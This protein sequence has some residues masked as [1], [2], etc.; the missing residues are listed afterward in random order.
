MDLR[1]QLQLQAERLL[2]QASS[3]DPIAAAP[4][5][6]AAALASLA[7]RTTPIVQAEDLFWS[8]FQQADCVPDA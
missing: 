4:L 5:V 3:M 2:G 7:L 1:A 6:S 8:P